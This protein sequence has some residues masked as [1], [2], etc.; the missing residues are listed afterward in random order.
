MSICNAHN[1]IIRGSQAPGALHPM[2]T[3]SREVHV[4]G[5]VATLRREEVHGSRRAMEVKEELLGRNK[6]GFEWILVEF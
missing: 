5:R 2:G 3:T 4:R 1:P 6:L